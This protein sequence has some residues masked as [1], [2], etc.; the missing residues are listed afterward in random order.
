MATGG[1]IVSIA[2]IH[3]L[4]GFPESFAYAASKGAVVA[5]ARQFAIDYAASDLRSNTVLPGAVDTD[6]C[7]LEWAEAADPAA[8]QRADEALHLMNRMGTAEEVAEVVAFLLSPAS[9]LI[10][11]QSIVVD[12]G[13][14]ARAPFP[15]TEPDPAGTCM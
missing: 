1:S 10:N 15:R 4:M 9:S 6:M 11:G 3:A 14:T 12:G 7:R 2:S 8:A 5:M 13:A